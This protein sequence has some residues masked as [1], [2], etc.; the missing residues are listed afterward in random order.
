MESIKL[1]IQEKIKS[2]TNHGIKT[3]LGVG[4]MSNNIIDVTIELADKFNVP[5]MLIASRRQI[6]S[7]HHG[8]GYVNNWTTEN[9]SKYVHDK[10]KSKSVVLA[11]DHGGPWQNQLEKSNCLNLDQ[12]MASA[13]LS[14][15]ADIDAG[16]KILHIDPSI[17]IDGPVSPLESLS[18]AFELYEHCWAYA[19]DRGADIAFEIGTEEQQASSLGTLDELE[20]QLNSINNFC[21]SCGI[22]LPLYVVVQA[23]TKVMEMR[24]CWVFCSPVRVDSQV[25]SEILVPK[26]VEACGK[27]SIFLKQHNTDYLSDHALQAHPALGIHAANVAP[28]IWGC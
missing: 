6:D 19:Q 14:Y 15:E 9:F 27:H 25:P 12:A 13:K 11:R 23:G 8:G 7:E 4:P 17:G 10:D 21:K 5:L 22:P 16:F 26:I 3:L 20:H 2:Y 24:K 18:R 1:N 28:E